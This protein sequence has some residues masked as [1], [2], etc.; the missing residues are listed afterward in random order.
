MLMSPSGPHRIA[1]S[2]PAPRWSCLAPPLA[3]LGMLLPMTG[4]QASAQ[5]QNLGFAESSDAGENE[6]PGEDEG[7]DS[8]DGDLEVHLLFRRSPRES[9][10]PGALKGTCALLAVEGDKACSTREL[11][12]ERDAAVCSAARAPMRC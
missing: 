4:W 7:G 10:P 2:W 12:R 3:L 11:H 9:F 5:L 6:F 8:A 1:K